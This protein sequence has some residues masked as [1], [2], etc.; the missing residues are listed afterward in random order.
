MTSGLLGG[1]TKGF[2]SVRFKR[3][4]VLRVQNSPAVAPGQPWLRGAHSQPVLSLEKSQ[5]SRVRPLGLPLGDL[6]SDGTGTLLEV[7][8]KS[9]EISR[10]LNGSLAG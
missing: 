6:W 2:R 4:D 7:G 8:H 10:E 5:T 9:Q 1:N 3:F